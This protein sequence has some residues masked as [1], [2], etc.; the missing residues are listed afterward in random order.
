MDPITHVIA[1][2][3]AGAAA[4]PNAPWEGIAISATAALLP[5]M[6]FILYYF[7]KERFQDVH[8]GPT[9]SLLGLLIL[10]A[11]VGAAA[12]LI[13]GWQF[14]LAA[15][16]AAIGIASHLFLDFVLHGVGL[17]PF[18]PFSTKR[19]SANLIMGLNPHAGSIACHRKSTLVCM[20]CQLHIDAFAPHSYLFLAG[21]A[22][23]FITPDWRHQIALITAILFGAYLLLT[24]GFKVVATGKLSRLLGVKVGL[25]HA[26]PASSLP[27]AWVGVASRNGTMVTGAVGIG[28]DE[29]AEHVPADGELVTRAKATDAGRFI[30]KI[31]Q[32][33]TAWVESNDGQV[34]VHLEDLSHYG[35]VPEELF[36][37][38]VVFDS[39]GR[40]IA[41]EFREKWITGAPGPCPVKPSP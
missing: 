41:G 23:M 6:D 26:Y 28:S 17:E 14:W 12:W 35:V 33:T 8:R 5:D 1:G 10:S 7:Y 36:S 2:G 31:G 21:T 30:L 40:I 39:D 34:T 9:H 13:L 25:E 15:G 38:R 37:T 32:E 19:F 11:L 18:W 20:K 29:V 16:V 24:L 22:G 27:W 3:L 4:M